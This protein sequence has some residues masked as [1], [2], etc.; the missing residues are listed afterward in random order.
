MAITLE[1]NRE[2]IFESGP[3]ASNK[4]TRFAKEIVKKKLLKSVGEKRYTYDQRNGQCITI[5]T[6]AKT[7]SCVHYFSKLTCKHLVAGCIQD[8][9][10]LDGLR[11]FPKRLL[12]VRRRRQYKY[13]DDSFVEGDATTTPAAEEQVP[14]V[15]STQNAQ[16]KK[17]KPRKPKKVPVQVVEERVVD[18]VVVPP[19]VEN[20]Q[21]KKKRGRKPKNAQ[22]EVVEERVVVPDAR[23]RPG[24]VTDAL[25]TDIEP[26]RR[27]NRNKH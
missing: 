3:V 11:V 19:P 27:S 6:L 23:G 5:D 10:G 12:T 4:S 24:R 22:V 17:R 14:V 20:Q 18:P 2:R 15:A 26:L 1:S 7:C 25:N 9:V 13:V 21:K 16:K 8:Q